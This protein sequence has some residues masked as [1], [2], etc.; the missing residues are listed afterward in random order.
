MKLAEGRLR[1]MYKGF[2]PMFIKERL[3]HVPT[4]GFIFVSDMGD[5]FGSWVPSRWIKSV[6]NA[7][8]YSGSKATFL[9]LTKDPT[10]YHEFLDYYRRNMLFGTTIES[11]TYYQDL[12][13]GVKPPSP[14]RRYLAM[15]E[16][17][18]DVRRFISVEP[19]LKF[20]HNRF[21]KWIDDINPELIYIGYDNYHN[22]LP[23]PRLKD[24]K[25]LIDTL[26][27]LGYRVRTKTLRKAW[28]E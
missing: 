27:S 2:D 13:T 23:E 6:F 25:R 15:R 9:F 4:R 10:R 11:N 18:E 3:K 14:Y 28:Y 8:I 26:E 5:L 16:L 20:N 7:I 22:K 19:I 1:H 21:V 17:P 12:Y 24:T